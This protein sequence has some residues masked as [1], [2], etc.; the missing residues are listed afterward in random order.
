MSSDAEKVAQFTY[1]SGS[2]VPSLPTDLNVDQV[3]FLIRMCSSELVELAQTV[4][5]SWEDAV[6]MVKT[7]A[8]TDLKKDY[9][10]PSSN[11]E[12]IAHQA[13]AAV[14]CWYYMLNTFAKHGINLSKVFNVV[15]EA[16]MAKKF[17]DGT[18]HTR[19]DG[20]VI[21]PPNWTEPNIIDEI[22]KQI[23]TGNFKLQ[24]F[25]DFKFEV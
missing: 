8:D 4:C 1:E 21:K 17:P 13:D 23:L 10:K 7:A 9:K 11:I 12:I 24:I 25:K 19:S 16:N 3:R 18:F 20:K 6:E 15:H 14:D 2:P 22:N 5:P